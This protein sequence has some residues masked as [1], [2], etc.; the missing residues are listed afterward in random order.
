MALLSYNLPLLV[1]LKQIF[2][3]FIN[4]AIHHSSLIIRC[5]ANASIRNPLPICNANYRQLLNEC[6]NRHVML[7]NDIGRVW[8]CDLST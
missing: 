3:K 2:F 8:L 7:A 4:Q 6:D 5:V 1:S